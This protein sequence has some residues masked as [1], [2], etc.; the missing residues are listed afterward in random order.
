[1]PSR[2]GLITYCIQVQYPLYPVYNVD[3]MMILRLAPEDLQFLAESLR[4]TV[5]PS[6]PMTPPPESE[7]EKTPGDEGF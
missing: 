1:M 2:L 7:G 5:T 4:V 6:M 3:A